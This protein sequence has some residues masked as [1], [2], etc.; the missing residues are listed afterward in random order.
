MDG[1]D[2]LEG[3]TDD[4]RTAVEEM[5]RAV[6]WFHRAR[7]SLI[8]Y[9]HE[10]GHA[11]ERVDEV[12][13]RLEGEYD[14]IAERLREEIRPA[15]VT[16]D[17]KTTYELVAEFEEGLFSDVESV[18]DLTFEEVADGEHHPTARRKRER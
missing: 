5:E 1:T 7:G 8:R 10:L 6:E 13:T 2:P 14:D 4:E 12:E 18:A 15:G 16:A 11:M 3:L 17:G 9:H